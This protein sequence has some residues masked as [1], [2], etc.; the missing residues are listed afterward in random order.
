MLRI[1]A[2][3]FA[4]FALTAHAN[5]D[6]AARVQGE[7]LITSPDNLRTWVLQVKKH[8]ADGPSRV[9]FY[10]YLGPNGETFPTPVDVVITSG[11]SELKLSASAGGTRIGAVLDRENLFAGYATTSR[12]SR[13][14]RMERLSASEIAERRLNIPVFPKNARVEVIYLSTP[15]CTYCAGWNG[16]SRSD[17]LAFIDGKPVRFIEVKGDTLR[18]PIHA[19]HYPANYAWVY[20]QIGASRG[21]PRFLLAIDSKVML[22]VFGTVG[23]EKVF[24]PALKEVIVRQEAG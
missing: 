18:L 6:L 15:D 16:R 9:E 1:I 22:N 21:V 20:E 11:G 13:P 5:K 2:A 24:F 23:Y 19:K 10:G 8:K 14:I 12:E 3:L 4:L 17:L 7:W